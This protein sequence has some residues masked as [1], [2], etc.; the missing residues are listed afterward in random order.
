MLHAL[1]P[2]IAVGEHRVA[3]PERIQGLGQIRRRL[4][5]KRAHQGLHQGAVDREVQVRQPGHGGEGAVVLGA[6]AP[7]RAN[8][9]ERTGLEAGDPVAGDEA[10][11][12]HVGRPRRNDHLVEAGR[13]AVDDIH[14]LHEFLVLLRT[15]L[16]GDEDGEMPD[17]M[18]QAI[19]DRLAGGADVVDVPIQIEDPA[20]RLRR[21]TDIVFRRGEHDDRRGDVA[22][23]ENRAVVRL[24]LI[25]GQLVADEEIV[26][27]ELQLVAVQQDEVAPPFLE[28]EVALRPGV[29]VGIDL[30][31]LAPQPVRRA[32]AVEVQDQPGPSNLPLPRSLVIAVS[33]L[34]PSRP[35]E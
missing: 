2:G 21:R 30:V 12:G 8:V 18:A 31:L 28:L 26:H 7:E 19:D 11:R 9:V 15:H 32:Q 27:Q 6:V 3:E 20:E 29:D 10:A 1:H 14:Q 34:P 16:G 17:L 35:P 24:Q 4:V 23:I 5:G 13:Q 33:Q 25:A 22:E